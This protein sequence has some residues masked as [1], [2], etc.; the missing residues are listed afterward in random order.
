MSLDCSKLTKP[1]KEE[2]WKVYP[3]KNE[4]DSI[5]TTWSIRK[6]KITF[7]SYSV[8]CICDFIAD[9]SVIFL[10]A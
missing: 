8:I 2:L 5:W 3:G 1:H 10:L 7:I 4:G 9:L 6:M